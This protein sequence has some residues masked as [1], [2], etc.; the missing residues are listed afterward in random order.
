MYVCAV[1]WGMQRWI[2]VVNLIKMMWKLNP[3]QSLRNNFDIQ[4]DGNDNA[5]LEVRC[6]V[7]R[8]RFGSLVDTDSF[9]RPVVGYGMSS[10]RSDF[11]DRGAYPGMWCGISWRS[12][13]RVT[14]LARSDEILPGKNTGLYKPN[15]RY[16]YNDYFY[17]HLLSLLYTR[18]SL[19]SCIT[20]PTLSNTDHG[21]H[22]N[23]N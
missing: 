10:N 4:S 20:A 5:W 13:D 21:I 23:N 22:H 19:R 3:S 8:R 9:L 18:T 15:H 11:W 16:Y 6:T 17:Y 7:F 14:G 1:W 12:W 2:P